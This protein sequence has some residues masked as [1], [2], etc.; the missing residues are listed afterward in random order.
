[1]L[2]PGA[3]DPLNPDHFVKLRDLQAVLAHLPDPL[4][5]TDAT[6]EVLW[7]NPSA[8]TVFV[9][10]KI[11]GNALTLLD[12]PEV[13][14]AFQR[15]V[16]DEAQCEE[17]L[18]QEVNIKWG[19]LKRRYL[20]LRLV[21]FRDKRAEAPQV[22]WSVHDMTAQRQLDKT[23]TDF[24][25]A[26]SHELRTPL[27][28]L[29]GFVETLQGPAKDDEDAREQFLGI[30]AEQARRMS[31]LIDDLLSLSKIEM[32]EGE[33]PSTVV[34][35]QEVVFPVTD[36]LALTARE[37]GI[38]FAFE[39]DWSTEVVGDKDQLGQVFSN[40]VENAIKYGHPD[41]TITLKS[42]PYPDDPSLHSIAVCDQSPG[43][44]P[45]H[46]SRLTERF[47]RVDKARSRQ[48]GGT[49]LGLAIVKHILYR[50]GGRL[51]ISSEQDVGSTFDVLLPHP[52]NEAPAA[53]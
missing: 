35:L 19:G 7:H 16:S 15:V 49:G 24:V 30:M 8:S 39:G 21:C 5:H 29:M 28:S 6:G 32:E 27:A 41:S 33:S 43:I 3:F 36:S 44:A 2:F 1:M 45:K 12:L 31:R 13:Q 14:A 22:L 4:I 52:L 50:H 53:L 46:L 9:G 51:L 40:L 20:N 10:M 42:R 47:Y 26:A 25:A 48:I 34:Q 38:R 18:Q 17:G 11:G 23:R 37:R